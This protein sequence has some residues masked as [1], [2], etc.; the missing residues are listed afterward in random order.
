MFFT[1]LKGSME[2]LVDRDPEEA[3]QLLDPVLVNMM[4]AVQRFEGT[5]NL[6]MGDGIKALIGVP[7]AHE[8]DAQRAVWTGLG[9]VEA[10]GRLN[11]PSHDRSS[12]QHAQRLQV[13]LR[14]HTGLAVVGE[15]VGGAR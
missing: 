8:D 7:Q 3:R 15:I 13:R 14:I 12:T 10:M 4:E 6:M 5:V 9:M 1:D 2:L 11:A